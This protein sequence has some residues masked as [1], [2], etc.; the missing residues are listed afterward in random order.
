MKEYD[1]V[2][3]IWVEPE[4]LTVNMTSLKKRELCRGK[5]PHEFK[6]IIPDYSNSHKN[7]D[8]SQETIMLFYEK[9]DA[10]NEHKRNLQ[11]EINELGINHKVFYFHDTNAERRHYVCA[12]CGKREW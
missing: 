4:D 5:K 9:M 10:L 7:D 2:K 12:V 6:L 8:L 11:K 1:R 3:K